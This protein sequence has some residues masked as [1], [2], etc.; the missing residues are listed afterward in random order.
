MRNYI[1]ILIFLLPFWSKAQFAEADSVKK[2]WNDGHLNPIEKVHRSK[3]FFLKYHEGNCYDSAYTLY[4]IIRANLHQYNNSYVTAY[5]KELIGQAA[6]EAGKYDTAKYYFQQSATIFEKLH[7]DTMLCEAKNRLGFIFY[8][9]GNYEL[10]IENFIECIEIAEKAKNQG[11]ISSSYNL[12]GLA[13]YEKPNPDYSKALAYYLKSYNALLKNKKVSPI[14]L[15]RIGNCYSK[16]KN[17]SLAEIILTRALNVSDSVGDRTSRCWTLFAFGKH[18]FDLK[19]YNQAIG[20]F[21]QSQVY[22]KKYFDVPGIIKSSQYLANC[23]YFQNQNSKALSNIDSTIFYSLKNNVSQ[24]LIDIYLLKSN[25]LQKSEKP[26]GALFF[27]KMYVKTKDSLF[28]IKNNNNINELEAKFNNK[29]KMKEISFLTKQKQLDAK[30]KN[31]LLFAFFI[32]V[33]FIAVACYSIY[34]I[35]VSKKIL[36]QKNIEI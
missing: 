31:I 13:F 14:I 19:N 20:Y 23:Y 32:S 11:L 3:K 34:K 10:A 29:E 35:N 27:Y 36:N 9:M 25:I 33:I 22:F 4:T 2:I 15:M 26:E 30:I 28:N 6:V 7:N 5:S 12:T 16:L 21:N 1:K 17:Y 8:T 18:Y 24:T